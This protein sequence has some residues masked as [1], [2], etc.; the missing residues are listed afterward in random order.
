MIHSTSKMKESGGN[1]RLHMQIIPPLSIHNLSLTSHTYVIHKEFPLLLLNLINLPLMV[2]SA[3]VGSIGTHWFLGWRTAEPGK[4]GRYG[5]CTPA[6][7]HNPSHWHS[8]T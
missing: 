5:V 2:V 7:P 8:D 4:S 3:P 6:Q 1:R